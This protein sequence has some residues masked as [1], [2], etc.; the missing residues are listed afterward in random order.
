MEDRKLTFGLIDAGDE[1]KE[2]AFVDADNVLWVRDHQGC[3]SGL[4]GEF[5]RIGTVVFDGPP[6][7]RVVVADSPAA[8]FSGELVSLTTPDRE[9]GTTRSPPIP[10]CTCGHLWA[11]HDTGGGRCMM[12]DCAEYQ[13]PEKG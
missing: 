2:I 6:D 9:P 11:H 1:Y 8:R 12:C 5:R 4:P 7:T 13:R 10:D 3:A